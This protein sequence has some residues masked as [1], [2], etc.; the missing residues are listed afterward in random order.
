MVIKCTSCDTVVFDWIPFS[1]FHTHTTGMTHF[2]MLLSSLALINLRGLL[3]CRKEHN[4]GNF[5]GNY[6]LV[7]GIIMHTSI[8]FLRVQFCN[9]P[10]CLKDKYLFNFTI[11]L[12]DCKYI[13][14]AQH[15]YG[16][17][18]VIKTKSIY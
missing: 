16:Y 13:Y 6:R 4:S 2:L 11:R 8:L 15:D 3:S 7:T 1:K 14:T 12:S 5:S 10:Q 17:K 18:G 9:V